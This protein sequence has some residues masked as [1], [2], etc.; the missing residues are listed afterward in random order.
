MNSNPRKQVLAAIFGA[1]Q[2]RAL[3]MMAELQIAEHLSGPG[4]ST[5]QLAELT[6]TNEAM[7]ERLLVLLEHMGL[8]TISEDGVVRNTVAGSLLHAVSEGSF[9]NYAQLTNSE[10]VLHM[11]AYMR[12]SL[13]SGKSVFEQQ[14][15]ISFYQGLQ[16]NPEMANV[17]NGAMAEISAQDTPETLSSF[18]PGSANSVLDIGGGEGHLL[19]A[20]LDKYPQLNA[21]LVELPAVAQNAAGT[22]EA[23]C[24]MNRCQVYANDFL[25][26]VPC[27]AD[28]VIL[29]RVLSHCSDNDALTLLENIRSVMTPGDRLLIIDPDTNSLYGASYNLLMVSVVGAAG[30]R[31]EQELKTLFSKTGFQYVS[32]QVL[33]TELCIVEAQVEEA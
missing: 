18:D 10:M 4:L 12:D 17:F 19:A 14:N 28:I 16:Q 13:G 30:V 20:L 6:S 31:S 25:L 15:G 22:L 8:L 7:L 23:Y 3:S 29:K 26:E 27:R 5:R 1:V 21:A 33:E 24:E 2:S 32:K 11:L 9:A